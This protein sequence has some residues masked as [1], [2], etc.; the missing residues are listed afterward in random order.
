MSIESSTL[1]ITEISEVTVGLPEY[2]KAASP[3]EA[4]TIIKNL[5]A[6]CF[7]ARDAIRRNAY[8]IGCHLTDQKPIVGHSNWLQ[9]L[10]DNSYDQRRAQERIK[11]ARECRKADRLLPISLDRA[12]D[13]SDLVI[14]ADSAYLATESA[15]EPNNEFYTPTIYIE[16]TRRVLG[17]IDLDPASDPEANAKVVKAVKFYT[18]EDDGLKQEWHGRVFCNPP[19][20]DGLAKKFSETLLT[21][22]RSGRTTAAILLLST[23]YTTIQPWF[24]ALAAIGNICLVEGKVEWWGPDAEKSAGPPGILFVYLGEDGDLFRE[25]FSAFGICGPM[26]R[27]VRAVEEAA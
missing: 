14:S 9:W 7:A 25:E 10:R 8:L 20:C 24:Q 15:S 19:F 17:E 26:E 27:R 12:K 2:T 4:A 18:R 13:D 21:E 23:T 6:S 3:A 22:Y 5:D 11:Y 1:T 16:A